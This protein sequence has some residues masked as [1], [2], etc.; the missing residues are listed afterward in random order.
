[1]STTA[2]PA[3]S[4]S[5]SET[6]NNNNNLKF[7]IQPLTQPT[8][9]IHLRH[10][11]K[12]CFPIPYPPKFYDPNLVLIDE[13]VKRL[14]FVAV[15]SSSQEEEEDVGLG[16][17]SRRVVGGIRCRLESLLPEEEEEEEEEEKE[18]SGEGLLLRRQ[19]NFKC[20][21]KKKKKKKRERRSNKT[22]AVLPT[23]RLLGIDSQLLDSDLSFS[24]SLSTPSTTLP[25][26]PPPPTSVITTTST[27]SSILGT[28]EVQDMEVEEEEEE[29]EVMEIT[30]HVWEQNTDALEWYAKRDF[31]VDD[32]VGVVQGYYRRLKPGGARLVR[33]RVV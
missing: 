4:N 2:T 17:G 30:A 18:S 21:M 23:Y 25:S 7:Q 8:E 31:L 11:D 3:D 32:Q 9:L 13:H 26:L 15:L 10:L 27:S 14:N 33:R 1:M 19:H 22:L 6:T 5:H 24:P 28:N 29:E 16:L 12:I 20:E